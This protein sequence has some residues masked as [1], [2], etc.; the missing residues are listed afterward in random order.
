MSR[1]S[2]IV[3]AVL[4][5]A[6]F[7]AL[8]AMASTGD[9]FNRPTLGTGWVVI[10]PSLSIAGNQL[11]GSDLGLGYANAAS[12]SNA[13]SAVVSLSSTA[14][15]YGAVAVGQIASGN[16]AF[17]KLQSQNGTTSFDHAAFYTGNN[18]SGTFFALTS[19][20][21]SPATLDVAFCGTTA[22]MRITSAA[23]VQVYSHDYGTTFGKGAGL[24]TYGNGTLDNFVAYNGTCA[25]LKSGASVVTEIARNPASQAADRTH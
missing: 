8:P 14:L 16:N 17:V 1:Y 12:G 24:G 3:Q 21:P 20:V 5:L 2:N 10:S 7:T 4:C 13:A 18:G 22:V 9:S 19:A 11:V 6:A 23:G 25:S 15:S